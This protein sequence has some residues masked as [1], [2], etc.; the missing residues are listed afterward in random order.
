MPNTD[1]AKKMV[2][3]IEKRTLINKMRMSRIKT[4][5]K[6][7]RTAISLN[8][9]NIAREA[10]KV[11]QPEIH[12]GVTKKVM[13]KNKAARILSRLSKHIKNM[14]DSSTSASA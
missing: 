12:R 10:F 3:K 14:N 5:I 8:D 9:K 4:F 6:K 7:V 11:A 2:R 1:S 13:H